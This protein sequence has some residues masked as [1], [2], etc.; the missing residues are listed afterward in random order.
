MPDSD[1]VLPCRLGASGTS[2]SCATNFS[3]H[4][5][6]RNLDNASELS[7]AARCGPGFVNLP[8]ESV[9]QQLAAPMHG[10][11]V[12]G[13]GSG[14][15]SHRH[16]PSSVTLDEQ[17]IDSLPVLG[18][19]FAASR[20]NTGGSQAGLSITD[21]VAIDTLSAEGQNDHHTSAVF[22]VLDEC[23][24]SSDGAGRDRDAST[25]AALPSASAAIA[26]ITQFQHALP[27]SSSRTRSV[28]Q[29]AFCQADGSA[30]IHL[31]FIFIPK[32]SLYVEPTF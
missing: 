19:E 10:F 24:F 5:S 7:G 22:A 23:R 18:S 26:R 27:R 25:S 28:Q 3:P 14:A 6:T 13:T 4:K 29:S 31:Q 1:G 15:A 8:E 32:H 17:N 30:V 20:S 2:V 12:P 21:E 9:S 11:G 16:D